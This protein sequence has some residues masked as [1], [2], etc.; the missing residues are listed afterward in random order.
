[1]IDKLDVEFSSEV[2]SSWT[3]N[4][5]QKGIDRFLDSNW[6]QSKDQYKVND[7]NK[8]D[9]GNVE[10]PQLHNGNPSVNVY[11]VNKKQIHSSRK[12]KNQNIK[13]K[14]NGDNK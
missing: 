4:Q 10:I 8:T 3:V 14:S 1:M 9:K 11:G 7:D 13:I 2:L 6:L 12:P 5:K